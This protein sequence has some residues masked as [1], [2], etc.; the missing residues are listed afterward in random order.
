VFVESLVN[1]LK[2][3]NIEKECIERKIIAIEILNEEAKKA[4][5]R[6]DKYDIDPNKIVQE[7]DFLE[8]S[9]YLIKN[10]IKFDLVVGNPPF[11]RYQ[12]FKNQNKKR[13]YKLIEEEININLSGLTNSFIPFL[14]LSTILLS[15]NG[16]LGMVIPIQLFQVNYAKETRKYLSKTFPKLTIITFN[17]LL[18]TKAQQEV[19]ILLGDKRP[20]NNEGIIIIELENEKELYN[21]IYPIDVLYNTNLRDRIKIDHS[22][23]KWTKYFLNNNDIEIINKINKDNKIKKLGNYLE[24]NIGAVT[25]KNSYFIINKKDLKK[26]DINKND[27]KK[28]ICRSAELEGLLFTKND[29][30]RIEDNNK[31]C[32]LFNPKQPKYERMGAG[33]R[34]YI[35]FG[36]KKGVKNGYKVKIRE[37]NWWIV[38][39]LKYSNGFMIRQVYKYPK[40]VVNKTKATC[41]DTIHRVNFKSKFEKEQIAISFLN[42]LTFAFSE[43]IGRNY[44]GGILSLE[45]NEAETIPLPYSSKVKYN[46]SEIDSLLREGRIEDILD[47]NDSQLLQEEYQINADE[48]EKLRGIWIKL[49]NRRINLNR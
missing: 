11:I 29:W 41:T 15:E 17:K 3:L 26:Y 16:K 47:M 20:K 35:D 36:L 5:N 31:K 49:R 34:N 43:I 44:G 38:P 4:K 6:I 39:S 28:I 46:V 24:V 19:V 32:L 2:S 37:P 45:P 12:D 42:S 22:D 21:K 8:Y 1:K 25:G 33:A 30:V 10:K 9:I 48:C 23:D 27:V 13:I 14:L 7:S 40:I 18:F